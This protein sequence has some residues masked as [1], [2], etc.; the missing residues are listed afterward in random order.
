LRKIKAKSLLKSGDFGLFIA[1]LILFLVLSFSS[2]SFLSNYNIFTVVRVLSLYIAIGLAQA[3]PLVIGNMNLSVGAIGGLATIATGYLLQDL[4]MP[5]WIAVIVA[6]TVGVIA[7]ALNGLLTAMAGINSFV[8]TLSTLFIYSGLVLGI[9]K[10]YPF[11]ELP[12]SFTFLGKEGFL[13][14]PL[15]FYFIVFVLIICYLFFYHSTFGRRI[16]ATGGDIQAAKLA[17][18]NTKMIVFSVHCMSGFI[19]A[20]TG[21][22]YVS[23]IGTAQPAAGSEWLVVSFAVAIIGGTALKGGY[24]SPLGILLGG[25]IMV[26]INNGLILIKAS[27]YFQETFFGLL[28]LMAIGIDRIREIYRG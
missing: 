16:L 20:L 2:K 6:L 23:R 13:N 15:L 1:V 11:T 9:T 4:G 24:I 25:I 27:I 10:G 17:G 5:G 7:G 12:K 22:L 26:L 28:I 18:V 19:A 8:V 21:I 14:I 3:F